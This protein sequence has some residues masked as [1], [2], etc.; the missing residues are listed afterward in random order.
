MY[1]EDYYLDVSLY[2]QILLPVI[3]VLILLLIVLAVSSCRKKNKLTV[4]AMICCLLCAGITWYATDLLIG[5]RARNSSY[6]D[7]YNYE[8][9]DEHYD[10]TEY[11]METDEEVSCNS[12]KLKSFKYDDDKWVTFGK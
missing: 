4:L 10:D 7:N 12:K 2:F 8:N 3:V 1:E 6:Y 9:D 5:M 11:Y